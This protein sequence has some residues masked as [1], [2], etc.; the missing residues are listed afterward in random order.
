MVRGW[1]GFPITQE[2]GEGHLIVPWQE[3]W[4]GCGDNA[5]FLEIP[6]NWLDS[7][8]SFFWPLG[9]LFSPGHFFF[10]FFPEEGKDILTISP[11]TFPFVILGIERTAS[12]SGEKLFYKKRCFCFFLSIADIG[13]I[14]LSSSFNLFLLYSYRH[15]FLRI[16]ESPDAAKMFA[17]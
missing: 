8:F 1:M 2:M 6:M 16:V 7:P 12:A 10:F 9:A 15:L 4:Q 3:Y 5:V 13:E 11:A 14:K 17:A